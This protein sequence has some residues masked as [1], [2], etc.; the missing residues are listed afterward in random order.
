[1]AIF[2]LVHGCAQSAQ[3]WDLVK[4]EL[5]RRQHAVITP[6]L[7]AGEPDSSAS[8]Y[9]EVIASAIPEYEK[10]VVVAHSAS[11]WFLPLVASL[12]SVRRMVFLA[13][14]VPKIGTS[15]MELFEAETDMINPAWMGKDPR[16]EAIADEFL[17]HDCP[18]QR[19]P[20]AHATIRVLNLRRP[21]EE[22]YP[23]AQWPN[24][25]ASYIL[26]SADRTIQPTWSR[27]VA[28][29]QLHVEPI[30]LVAG[31]CPNVSRPQE[32]ADI[33]IERSL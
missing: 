4:A 10:P 16:T 26:C 15:F 11:G 5:E 8:R 21:W 29:T 27:R 33:L 1:M 25:P 23:L 3:G 24:V 18:P 19:L 20:W 31:H 9:A 12:R 28:R 7:P 14:A 22:H 17:F 32:L 6:E 30:E 13:A 2:V